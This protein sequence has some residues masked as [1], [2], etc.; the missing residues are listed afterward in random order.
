VGE[1]G[2]HTIPQIYTSMSNGATK[3]QVPGPE[4]GAWGQGSGGA[5]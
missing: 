1:G 5:G 2:P 4:K 3:W